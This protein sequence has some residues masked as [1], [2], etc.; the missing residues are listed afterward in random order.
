MTSPII[1]GEFPDKVV[2]ADPPAAGCGPEFHRAG[3]GFPFVPL[4][5]AGARLGGDLFHTFLGSGFLAQ[6]IRSESGVRAP[7]EYRR[8]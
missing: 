1:S 7:H 2:E 6:F 5:T 8:A 4:L 3:Q